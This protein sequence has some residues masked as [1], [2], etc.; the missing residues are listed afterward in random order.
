[1]I[2]I[3]ITKKLNTQNGIIEARFNLEI[4]KNSFFCLFG[5][6]GAGK[7]TLLRCLAGLERA[8]SGEIVVDGDIWFSSDKKIDLPPQKRS[9]G[10]VFQ[11][12][13]LFPTMSVID[14]L[15]Y[16]QNDRAKADDILSMMQLNELRDRL[17]STLSG[18]QQQRVAL[19]RALM[20][21]PKI[22]LLDEP[23]SALDSTI[24]AKLQDELLRVH[25]ELSLTTILVSHDI[26]EV[27]KLATTLAHIK[28][29][30][31]DKIAPPLEFLSSKKHS[32]KLQLI[33]EVLKIE[34]DEPIAIITLLIGSNITQ[35]AV[36]ISEAESLKVGKSVV[37]S[38]KA[39]NP[40]IL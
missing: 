9:I 2:K 20:R 25:K 27:S 38:A 19:S 18:G 28:N 31:I 14:N 15:L 1:M 30:N 40:M 7:T 13:A 34:L 5:E 22:L 36:S 6:S 23:L 11:D 12:Y 29:G 8:D 39:F 24:R 4:D 3:D 32:S 17:P 16:A 33:A 26:A 35:I 37:L 10:V 21:N